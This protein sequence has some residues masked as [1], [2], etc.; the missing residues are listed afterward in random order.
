MSKKRPRDN[1]KSSESEPAEQQVEDQDG[2][3]WT[4]AQAPSAEQAKCP[5]LD[6]VQRA[7][8]D[9]DMEKVCSVNLSD[10]HVYCCLVC[11]KFFQG[12]GKSTPAYTHSVHAGHFVFLHLQ[13]GSFFCLPDNYEIVDSSL[14]DIKSCLSPE[15]SAQD[16]SLL[17]S[18]KDLARDVHGSTYLPGFRGINNLCQTDYLNSIVHALSHVRPLRDF[19]L[20]PSRYSSS[21][22]ILVQH[23][24]AFMRRAWSAHNF[25]S[26][27]SPQEL[28]HAISEVS[29]KKFASGT[30]AECIDF[31]NWLL[32][33]LHRGL[34]GRHPGES[35]PAAS[36]KAPES[37]IITDCFQ[38]V[39]EVVELKRKADAGE[40][41][42]WS[43]S[44][45][46]VNFKHLSL[47]IPPPPLFMDGEDGKVIPQVPIFE[48]LSKF[49]GT[50]WT[51]TLQGDTHIRRKYR[52]ISLPKYL[53]FHLVRNSDKTS[54]RKERNP[55]IVTF[56]LKNLDMGSFFAA[57]ETAPCPTVDDIA[58]MGVKEL[59]ALVASHGTAE[60]LHFIKGCDKKELVQ[61]ATSAATN[62]GNAFANKSKFNLVANVCCESMQA[63][64]LQGVTVGARTESGLSRVSQKHVHPYKVH[65]HHRPT[66]K[67]FELNNLQVTEVEPQLIALSEASVLVYETQSVI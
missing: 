11:G 8:L 46:K 4:Q 60:Q 30:S 35:A 51:E 66:D 12:R 17:D 25:K 56:P 22:S 61:I 10:M 1:S 7:V 19:L 53:I 15:F 64:A 52:I 13:E 34:L 21:R 57:Q 5:Y 41:G 44:V 49:D 16:M 54:F 37:T 63:V 67:W 18:N 31:L 23:L 48:L 28:V 62:T 45:K 3:Q 65:L 2:G 33:E 32:G 39:I 24:G 20:Q 47:D 55:T 9:F 58:S 14:G 38:G 50:K 36:S 40:R 43:E 27:A 29:N 59:K 6:T 26:H 42:Q